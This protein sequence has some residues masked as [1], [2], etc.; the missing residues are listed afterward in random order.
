M[1]KIKRTITVRTEGTKNIIQGNYEKS[2][3]RK[4]KLKL[5]VTDIIYHGRHFSKHRDAVVIKKSVKY[6]RSLYAK[7]IC[8]VD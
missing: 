4:E 5:L 1:K 3:T 6:I 8:D 7:K 2:L